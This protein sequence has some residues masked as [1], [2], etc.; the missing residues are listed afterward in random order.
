MANSFGSLY[1]GSSSL[2]N[3]QNAINTTANNLANVGT[4]GHVRQQ[5]LFTDEN[6]IKFANAAISPQQYGLG[7]SI[8]DVVHTRDMF[9]DKLYR[10][11]SA[12]SAFYETS[13]EA[14]YEV[15]TYLQE[16]EGKQFQNAL[17]DFWNAF[18][19]FG[20]DPG[21]ST[22]QNMV[23]QKASLFLSRSKAVYSG[24]KSYQK[25]INTQI[26]EKIDKVNELAQNIFDL[27][28]EIQKI[29]AGGIETAMDLRDARDQA[30]DQLSAY[31]KIEYEE[32]PD[33]IVSVRF[34]NHDLLD[35]VRVYNMAK[36]TDKV[37]DFIT[38]YWPNTSDM[39]SGDLD[40]VYDLTEEISSDMNTDMGSIKAQLLARGDMT[41]TYYNLFHNADGSTMTSEQYQEGIGK[42]TMMNSLAEF[43]QLIHTMM[44]QIN[45][46][47]CPNTQVAEDGTCY[48]ADGNVL[49]HTIEATVNG[50][51][52]RVLAD[53]NG[54]A[55]YDAD[56]NMIVATDAKFLDV[57]TTPR[58]ED[59]QLPPQ[60]LFKRNGC[61]RYTEITLRDAAGN[62]VT[63][64]NGNEIKIW[65]YNEE[66]L[67]DRSKMYT[68]EGVSIN[69]DLLKIGTNLPHMKANMKDVDYDLGNKLLATWT[70]ESM[71]LSPYDTENCTFE[72]FYTKM[73]D[74]LAMN[75][76][77]YATATD[78][79]SGSLLST[80]NKRQEVIGVSTDEEL[81][82]MIKYQNGYNAASRYINVIAAMIDTL[83]NS[84]R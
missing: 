55:Y 34:E 31:G 72:K 52:V 27:N 58:G 64:A 71:W 23:I 76:N 8:G 38:P 70:T 36:Q 78:T 63:D 21:N 46:L 24:L 12:R 3:H 62:A 32:N 80:D 19:N 11:T 68:T 29:E 43:D 25:N 42:S 2:R 47:F 60:E 16:M 50:E 84:M 18:N 35:E 45:D 40:Y 9:L 51:T 7:V 33:G 4:T 15:Q 13:Y 67:N 66:D 82:N 20:T 28:Y 30:L 44:T 41:P 56:G 59:G 37:T 6:Y 65:K 73:V 57:N 81:T 77:I 1:I 83:L 10:S 22:A 26:S 39:T 17:K 69:G 61:D 74:E 79:L 14:A 53:E 48:D 54:N 75:G 49:Y 5:V